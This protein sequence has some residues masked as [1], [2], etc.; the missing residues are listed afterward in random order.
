MHKQYQYTILTNTDQS[1]SKLSI[2]QRGRLKVYK[3]KIKTK[4]S[5]RDI[6]H[7]NF[8]KNT[9]S[10]T[11]YKPLML[12]TAKNFD[13]QVSTDHSHTDK[14]GGVSR[15]VLVH[16]IMGIFIIL[17]LQITQTLLLRLLSPV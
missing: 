6:I 14:I 2:T 15:E 12:Y 17:C 9:K 8:N 7:T 10:N 1:Q 11:V 5:M 16:F 13:S 4:S 3:Q